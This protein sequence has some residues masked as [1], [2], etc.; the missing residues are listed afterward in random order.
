[1]ARSSRLV[2]TLVVAVVCVP[3][4]AACRS[5]DDHSTIVD[6]TAPTPAATATQVGTSAPRT[7]TTLGST[8]AATT[9]TEP[10]ALPTAPRPT[11]P[12]TAPV[13]VRILTLPDPTGLQ[14]TFRLVVEIDP[15]TG[16]LVGDDG[17]LLAWPPGWV[18]SQNPPGARGPDGPLV[19]VG[20]T[21]QGSGGHWPVDGLGPPGP[22]ADC[23]ANAA[24]Q[25]IEVLSQIDLRPAP[26]DDVPLFSV[27]TG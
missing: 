4:A 5:S 21:I 3:F 11:T 18:A 15:A 8:T 24:T 27:P 16:C 26:P 6:T 20:D 13:P 2:A 14:A 22:F 1:M 9:T 10:T 17:R 12:I 19:I 7:S 25:G 23:V